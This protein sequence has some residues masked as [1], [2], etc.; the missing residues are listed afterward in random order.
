MRNLKEFDLFKRVKG[1]ERVES[2][3]AYTDYKTIPCSNVRTK[4]IFFFLFFESIY[5]T[6][7]S[8]NTCTFERFIKKKK[9]TC[10]S[11]YKKTNTCIS[12]TR[13]VSKYRM[14][15]RVHEQVIDRDLIRLGKAISE[16]GKLTSR[17]NLCLATPVTYTS[18]ILSN[19]LERY[20]PKY[21]V[22]F[23][24]CPLNHST[25]ANM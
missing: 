7:M 23:R 4:R 15:R 8:W 17:R 24:V 3:K 10:T 6:P 22:K 1:F 11:K 9:N 2:K 25:R 16:R 12:E 18:T 20:D 21:V 19:R 14:Q 13:R 5:R